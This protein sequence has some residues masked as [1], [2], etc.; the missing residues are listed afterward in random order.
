MGGGMVGR[1]RVTK[2]Q[3]INH[4]DRAN[5][6]SPIDQGGPTLPHTLA[7]NKD[8]QVP[9]TLVAQENLQLRSHYHRDKKERHVLLLRAL[10]IGPIW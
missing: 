7:S 1:A 3:A 6:T 2:Q 9:A 10:M 5:T 8:N 4:P